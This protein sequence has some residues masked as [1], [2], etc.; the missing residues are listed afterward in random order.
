MS[1]P[2]EHGQAI[3]NEEHQCSKPHPENAATTEHRLAEDILAVLFEA[4]AGLTEDEILAVMTLRRERAIFEALEGLL[5]EGVIG[6]KHE[7]PP[8]RVAT[9]SDFA[10][11]GLTKE[12]VAARRK[13]SNEPGSS[14]A[15]ANK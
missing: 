11:W 4:K 10:F 3:N 9:S 1:T 8:D 2:V 12:E 6:A 15:T 5:L 13:G 7:A 14:P